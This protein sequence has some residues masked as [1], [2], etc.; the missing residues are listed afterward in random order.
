MVIVSAAAERMH[1][2]ALSCGMDASIDRILVVSHSRAA[3]ILSARARL[4]SDTARVR[5]LGVVGGF[6]AFESYK[7]EVVK[8]QCHASQ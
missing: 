5:F 3:L 4:T 7:I 6:E 1:E 8:D 2:N